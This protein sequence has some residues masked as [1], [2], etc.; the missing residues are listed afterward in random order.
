MAMRSAVKHACG[1]CTIDA[2]CGEHGGEM[3]R[4]AGASGCDQAARVQM[5]RTARNCAMS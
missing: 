2:C 4:R 3:L 5:S 1:Q